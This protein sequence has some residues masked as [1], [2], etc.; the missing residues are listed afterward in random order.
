MLEENDFK[1]L[2][3]KISEQTI[4]QP[5]FFDVVDVLAMI[6]IRDVLKRIADTLDRIAMDQADKQPKEISEADKM[7]VIAD[8]IPRLEKL[9]ETVQAHTIKLAGMDI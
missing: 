1:E 4:K 9:E 8:I 3:N 6:E 5:E 2:L 7:I